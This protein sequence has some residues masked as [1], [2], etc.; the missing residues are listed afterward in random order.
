MNG[1][2]FSCTQ[3]NGGILVPSQRCPYNIRYIYYTNPSHK[4]IF[5]TARSGIHNG[6]IEK[7]TIGNDS[8]LKAA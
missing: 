3:Q 4:Y 7:F 5:S 1:G 6:G 2:N 8:G